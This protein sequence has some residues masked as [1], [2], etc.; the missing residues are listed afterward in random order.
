MSVRVSNGIPPLWLFGATAGFGMMYLVVG[1]I[2]TPKWRAWARSASLTATAVLALASLA[3]WEG[4][5]GGY[6]EVTGMS[7][8]LHWVTEDLPT[9]EVG[10]QELLRSVDAL[11]EETGGYYRAGTQVS[12]VDSGWSVAISHP[13]SG[14]VC[15]V[16]RGSE[17]V[18]PA[19]V[20]GRVR[21]GLPVPWGNLGLLGAILVAGVLVTGF[22]TTEPKATVAETVE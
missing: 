2:R 11:H 14:R 10:P 22:V 1:T 5:G 13:V 6:W 17:S 19:V 3:G 18:W 12:Q 21:C 9:P 7:R 4:H 8:D 16:F 20:E 15:A